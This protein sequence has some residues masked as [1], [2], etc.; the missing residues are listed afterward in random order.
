MIFVRTILSQCCFRGRPS[1]TKFIPGLLVSTSSAILFVFFTTQKTIP[2]PLTLSY[3][4][5]RDAHSIPPP[6]VKYVHVLHIHVCTRTYIHVHAQGASSMRFSAS[7]GQ[8]LHNSLLVKVTQNPFTHMIL[9]YT[10]PRLC[11]GL[12]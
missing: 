3:Y 1:P 5:T 2:I 12:E 4:C 7:M 6:Y 11:N 8:T 10:G 9:W